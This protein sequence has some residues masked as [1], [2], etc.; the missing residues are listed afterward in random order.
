MPA[1]TWDSH[2]VGTVS[3]STPVRWILD[4]VR[5]LDISLRA[6]IRYVRREFGGAPCRRGPEQMSAHVSFGQSN[7]EEAFGCETG[8]EEFCGP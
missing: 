3:R 2:P 5:P 7:I 4:R 1:W 8:L 6:A